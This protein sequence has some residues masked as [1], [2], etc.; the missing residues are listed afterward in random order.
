MYRIVQI[1]GLLFRQQRENRYNILYQTSY[2]NIRSIDMNSLI[3]SEQKLRVAPKL[4]EVLQQSP[5]IKESCIPTNSIVAISSIPFKSVTSAPAANQVGCCNSN[6]FAR[7]RL[8]KGVQSIS[9]NQL[10]NIKKLAVGGFGVVYQAEMIQKQ[11]HRL[12]EPQQV[13]VKVVDLQHWH[14]QKVKALLQ[15]IAHMKRLD[16]PYIVKLLGIVNWSSTQALFNALPYFDYYLANMEIF[17]GPRMQFC[18]SIVM[19][20]IPAGT[21]KSL[22][23]SEHFNSKKTYLSWKLELISNIAKGIQY[24]HS[25]NI[26]HHDIKPGN[27]LIQ[28]KEKAQTKITDFGLSSLKFGDHNTQK[29]C[30]G[31]TK[32]YMAPEAMRGEQVDEKVDIWAL[33]IIMQEIF[34]GTP[35]WQGGIEPYVYCQISIHSQ[36]PNGGILPPQCP[37]EL[38]SLI[39]SCWCT[40]PKLRPSAQ[41]VVESLELFQ[42]T[43][44]EA[45]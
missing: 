17:N 31:G 4:S 20:L 34:T 15:E 38:Q 8:P 43:Y 35:P 41:Q 16:S 40:D 6:I 18:P 28:D 11:R 36:P 14:E 9:L 39:T 29:T 30:T 45:I 3:D 42:K 10:R 13:A 7:F 1:W 27:I 2:Y 24:L 37:Q 33:G 23:Y 19:E 12:L 22:L 26:I 25:Q 44:D 5:E 32:V 21:L